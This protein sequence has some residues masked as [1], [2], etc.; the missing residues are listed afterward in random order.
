MQGA[1]A[2]E[3]K[4][5]FAVEGLLRE[6]GVVILVVEVDLPVVLLKAILVV[7]VFDA[8][9]GRVEIVVVEMLP[10]QGFWVDFLLLKTRLL[11]F[12]NLA[13]LAYLLLYLISFDGRIRFFLADLL[14][15]LLVALLPKLAE[16]VLKVILAGL[17]PLFSAIFA[18]LL[19][20]FPASDCV[21][22]ELLVGN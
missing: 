7:V 11:L 10:A 12:L 19:G 5:A 4:G 2:R 9:R 8:V 14:F 3:V 16:A 13:C 6:I 15:R 20:F 21:D 18:R 22:S 1:S 17:L